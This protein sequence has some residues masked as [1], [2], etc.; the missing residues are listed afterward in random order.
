MYY[1]TPELDENEGRLQCENEHEFM[2]WH[3]I[4]NFIEIVRETPERLFE[5]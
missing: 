3:D 4:D 2:E 5:I 1:D